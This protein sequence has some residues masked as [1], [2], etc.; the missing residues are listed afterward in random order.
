MDSQLVKTFLSVVATESFVAASERIHVTQS[1]V[2]QR[3]QKLEKML[4]HT[5]FDRSKS[6]AKLTVHGVKFEQYARSLSQLWDEARY[7]T[8]LPDGF[9]GNLNLGCEDSLWPELASVWLA[10]LNSVLPTTALNFQTGEPQTLSNK[11][12]RGTLDIAVLHMPIVRP[13]FQMAHV[14]DD[15]LVL[16]TGFENHAGELRD[17]YIYADWGVEFGMA[18]SRWFPNL[19]PPQTVVKLGPSIAQY[20][21]DNKRTAFLPYRIADDYVASGQLFFVKD[22]PEFPFPSYAVWTENK[23]AELIDQALEQLKI[24]AKDA[25]WIEI[26]GHTSLNPP[27]KF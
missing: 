12:L 20:L 18:H 23:P 21:I 19:P 3:I 2:S 22:G 17:D 7:Q 6:G 16:V 5:L 8:A 10:K 24:A 14:L 1:T 4:G 13:G 11:L 27:T 9:S 15:I 26:D 25:P